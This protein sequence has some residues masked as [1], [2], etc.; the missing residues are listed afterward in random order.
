MPEREFTGRFGRASDFND[1]GEYL[2]A[3]VRDNR[4]GVYGGVDIRVETFASPVRSVQRA[5]SPP[6]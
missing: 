6:G 5:L 1:L 3:G 2:A 4:A